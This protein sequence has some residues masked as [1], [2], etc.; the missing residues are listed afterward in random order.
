MESPASGLAARGDL[1]SALPFLPVV[2]RGGALFWPPVAQ[3]SLRA[4]ALGPDV[5]R[6]ASGD[7]LADALTDLRLALAL[8]PLPV[9]AAEGFALFFDDLLSREHAR[10]WFAEVLPSLAR[11]LLRLP[12]L[13]EDH[14]ADA[15]TGLR[16]LGSQDA[17]IVFLSQEL[18]SALLACALFCLLPT[19]GRGEASLPT[20]N[21][22]G[23]FSYVQSHFVPQT[24]NLWKHIM[25]TTVL[26]TDRS[27]GP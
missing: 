24:A 4:L 1:L 7:V 27:A 11:L 22:D 16:I 17:G 19:R 2:L 14:Y 3:E 20:I 9:R 21:F 18:V 13:L 8:P 26:F 15:A 12:A 23:L 5:S 25:I 10:G 6:V